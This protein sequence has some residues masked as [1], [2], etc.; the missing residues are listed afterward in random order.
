MDTK[1]CTRCQEDKSLDDFSKNKNKKDGYNYICRECQNE[2]VRQHY[3]ENRQKYIDKSLKRKQ[4]AS[5]FLL[6]YKVGK[7]CPYCPE[8]DPACFDFHHR[9]P[10][11]KTGNVCMMANQGCSIATL[12]QEIEKCVL[13][14][15]NCHRKFHAGRLKL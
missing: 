3:L 9:N 4:E 2:Y 5:T 10:S 7:K 12:I 11:E 6:E 8:T 13:L 15:S 1:K 14:C